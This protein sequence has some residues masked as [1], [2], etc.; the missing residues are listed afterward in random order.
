MNFESLKFK[1]RD[2]IEDVFSSYLAVHQFDVE[3]LR[4]QRN[5]AEFKERYDNKRN[6]VDWDF[7]FGLKDFC[8]TVHREE[9][10]RFRLTGVSFE[11]RLAVGTVPNR[12][13]GSFIPG[14]KVSHSSNLIHDLETHP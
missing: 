6:I 1:E 10:R 4:D 8:E 7:N 13:M 12:T 5:R 11:T 3:Q 9:Y 14:K 2:D